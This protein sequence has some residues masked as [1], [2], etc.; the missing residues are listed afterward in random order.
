M[1]IVFDN[2][3]GIVEGKSPLKYEG[4]VVGT[5]TAIAADLTTGTVTVK[6]RLTASA[7]PIASTGS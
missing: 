2:A 3:E 1:T 7:S 6:A 5:V 4:V